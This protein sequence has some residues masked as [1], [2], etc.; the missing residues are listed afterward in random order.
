MRGYVLVA[1]VVAGSALLLFALG[2]WTEWPLLTDP[3]PGMDGAGVAAA[4]LGVGLLTADVVLPVPSSAVMVGHGALFGV[5]PGAALSLVG[6]VSATVVGFAVGRRGRG[7]LER[8]TTPA[9]RVRADRL[10]TRWG[11]WAVVV[12]RAVPVLAETVAVLAGTS[13]MRWPV[14]VLAGAAG[15]ALPACLYAAAGAGAGAA[16]GTA[17][18]VGLGLALA[19][20]L[21]AA[22]GRPARST[23][24]ARRPEVR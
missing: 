8:G 24:P 5:V 12:S 1:A 9:Q 2:E 18:A 15:T 23:P 21:V 20:A 14:L 11:P 17:L 10:L 19:A 16:A 22:G 4:L 6:G 3:S 7:V 13:S